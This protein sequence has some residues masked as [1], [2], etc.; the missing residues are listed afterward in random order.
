MK[1]IGPTDKLPA[2]T[3]VRARSERGTVVSCSLVLESSGRGR[4]CRH[5]VNL[6]ERLVK[7]NNRTEWRAIEPRRVAVNYSALQI[8]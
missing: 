3:Q 1:R 5:V 6:T 8:L 4:I 2:G 7:A